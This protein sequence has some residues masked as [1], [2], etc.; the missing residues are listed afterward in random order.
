MQKLFTRKWLL[1]L[2]VGFLLLSIIYIGYGLY[3]PSDCDG[4]YRWKESAYVLRGVNPF[5]VAARQISPISDIGPLN[6][7]G[8]NMPWTYLLSNAIYPG[9]LPYPLALLWARTL[10]V[11]L[12]VVAILRLR[13]YSIHELG[14]KE[15]Q[16]FALIFVFF[17]NY[18]WFATLRLGNH[19]AYLML[20][21]IILFTFDHNK[22]WVLAGICYA[23]L[24]MKPQTTGIFLLYYLLTKRWKP[25][26]FAGGILLAVVC[27]T[28]FLIH[29]TPFQMLADAY[30]LCVSYEHLDN[31]IYYGLLDPLVSVFHVPSRIVLPIGMALGI[32]AMVFY[33][34]RFRIQSEPVN[35]AVCALLSLCWMY[36][37]TS[38]MILLG[39]IG[40][41]CLQS[42]FT[43]QFQKLTTIVLFIGGVFGAIPILGTFYMASPLVPL[44]VRLIYFVIVGFLVHTSIQRQNTLED[45]RPIIA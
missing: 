22:N 25:I 24:L 5:A 2:C 8:G 38:D 44:V 23:F 14:M 32:G 9:F 45:A 29:S 28:S 20:I 31:Y 34:F 19:A 30:G 26:L 4:L 13:H 15:P 12:L 1:L 33:R 35:N 6:T 11:I 40:F 43:Y 3:V 41:A 42:V 17:A 37:Q 16:N 39:F 7:D 36:I 10:F 27:V 21:L 18:M